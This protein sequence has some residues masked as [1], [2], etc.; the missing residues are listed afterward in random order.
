MKTEIRLLYQKHSSKNLSEIIDIAEGH[1]S[2][3]EV[4]S[5]IEWLEESYFRETEKTQKLKE[6]NY[7]LSGI[8]QGLGRRLSLYKE[9]TKKLEN[10]IDKLS[11]KTQ[12]LG[13]IVDY[14]K[15]KLHSSGLR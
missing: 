6:K 4:L 13:K 2:L 11:T 14:Y 10:S 15:E 8:I 9:K 3:E 12:S 5:Y 1:C 7:K